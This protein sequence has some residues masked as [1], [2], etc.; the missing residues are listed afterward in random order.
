[1]PEVNNTQTTTNNRNLTDLNELLNQIQFKL[2]NLAQ[3]A[4]TFPANINRQQSR[5]RANMHYILHGM[6]NIA[7]LISGLSA[8]WLISA[9]L[10]ASFITGGAFSGLMAAMA[11][12]NSFLGHTLQTSDTQTID[13][14]HNK[15]ATSFHVFGLAA[16]FSAGLAIGVLGITNPLGFIVAAM[17]ITGG[18]IATYCGTQL[19]NPDNNDQSLDN[20]NNEL[21]NNTINNINNSIEYFKNNYSLFQNSTQN[22][23]NH[24]DHL[25]PNLSRRT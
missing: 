2:N 10:A 20:N 12:T 3:S 15:K 19:I 22:G 7:S 23:Q 24:H 16:Q 21:V 18:I 13:Q 17:G 11:L 8:G 6:G 14:P 9:S 5:A 4:P 25:Y 1:M